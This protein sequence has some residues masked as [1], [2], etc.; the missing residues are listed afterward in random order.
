M[1]ARV[2][3][4][5]APPNSPAR[6]VKEPDVIV[7]RVSVSGTIS[8]TEILIKIFFCYFLVDKDLVINI[9]FFCEDSAFI[10]FL[11]R[12]ESY[13]FVLGEIYIIFLR[14]SGFLDSGNNI[15]NLLLLLSLL[16][17]SLSVLVV[18]LIIVIFVVFR[19]FFFSE[20]VSA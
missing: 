4:G 10:C 6:G 11:E 20:K 14:L 5:L 13:C 1:R 18:L 16:L 7:I 3:V 8:A 19:V 17:Y 15:S 9:S 2:L 12:L